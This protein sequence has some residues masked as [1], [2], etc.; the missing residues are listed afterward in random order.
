MSKQ[1]KL[2]CCLFSIDLNQLIT[3]VVFF[4]WYKRSNIRNINVGLYRDD[5][6]AI[7]NATPRNTENIK[8]GELSWE[9]SWGAFSSPNSR[10]LI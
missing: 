10:I 5:G 3:A 6:L 1:I 4:H 9:L 8:K 2:N 7:T